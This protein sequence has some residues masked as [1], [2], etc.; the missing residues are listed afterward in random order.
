MRYFYKLKF[1]KTNY[2]MG[3]YMTCK[4][5]SVC[6]MKRF[7]ER[8]MLDKKWVNNYCKGDWSKCIRYRMEERGEYHPD[9]MLP[10]G[11]ID[12]NLR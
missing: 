12:D 3:D 5:Y 6:P 4:W 7:Y 9:C 2:R 11:T 1:T 10:D 8:G